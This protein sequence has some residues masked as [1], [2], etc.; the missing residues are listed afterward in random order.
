MLPNNCYIPII[1][2]ADTVQLIGETI[3]AGKFYSQPKLNSMRSFLTKMRI[4]PFN[5]NA[6]DPE[7]VEKDFVNMR[8]ESEVSAEDLHGLLVLSRLIGLGKGKSMLDRECWD[9]A[10]DLE[11]ERKGRMEMFCKNRN[12]A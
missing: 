7:M 10:K 6:E 5:M 4:Q 1:P 12:E 3:K 8:K 9:T 2:Q 11:Q